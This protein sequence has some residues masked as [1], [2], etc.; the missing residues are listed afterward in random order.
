[1]PVHQVSFLRGQQVEA[2]T[3][4]EY[5]PGVYEGRREVTPRAWKCQC[6][7]GAIRWVNA[8]N[9]RNGSSTS[10]GCASLNAS[11]RRHAGKNLKPINSVFAL[12]GM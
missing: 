5:R 7:C 2:W 4:L 6:S 11:K 8:G 10:C 9:L 1:M 12:G 3:L